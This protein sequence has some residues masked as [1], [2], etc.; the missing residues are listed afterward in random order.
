MTNPIDDGVAPA[1]LRVTGLD[2][3]SALTRESAPELTD[4]GL[5][6]WQGLSLEALGLVAFMFSITADAEEF[7]LHTDTAEWIAYVVSGS[8]T[9]Y[10]GTPEL[11]KTSGTTYRAGDFLTFEANTPHGWHNGGAASRIL[12]LRRGEPSGPGSDQVV[13]G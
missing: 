1:L 3:A 11:E 2:G 4:L 13:V 5:L 7:P 12:F 8:G 6:G 10:V 9:V